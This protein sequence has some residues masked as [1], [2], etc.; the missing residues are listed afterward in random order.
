[1]AF[2]NYLLSTTDSFVCVRQLLF[3]DSVLETK[4]DN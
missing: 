3:S 2:L 4:L 1:V